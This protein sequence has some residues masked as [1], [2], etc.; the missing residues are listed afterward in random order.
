MTLVEAAAGLLNLAA[1]IQAAAP[2]AP[3]VAG[4]AAARPDQVVR[5]LRFL[6]AAY[7]A[8]WVILAAYLLM[9]S[10]R[11]RR[12]ERQ[13]DRLRRRFGPDP[14]SPSGP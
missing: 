12:L 2:D 11:Q 1:A 7:T 13:L 3:F 9:L 6:T 10:V 8:V 4:E 5:G 14:T